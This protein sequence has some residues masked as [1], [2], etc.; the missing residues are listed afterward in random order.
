[1]RSPNPRGVPSAG[2]TDVHSA[3]PGSAAPASS[4]GQEGEF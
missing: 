4:S 2:R 3:D 1:M